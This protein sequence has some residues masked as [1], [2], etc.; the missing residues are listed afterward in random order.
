MSAFTS[1]HEPG[2]WLVAAILLGIVVAA[3]WFVVRTAWRMWMVIAYWLGIPYLALLTG[4]VSPRLMGVQFLD[5]PITFR[6]GVGLIIGLLVLVMVARLVLQPSADDHSVGTAPPTIWLVA[7]ATVGLCG[8]EQLFWC[9]LR[10][11]L[12]ELLL[13]V[14]VVALPAYWA[15]WLAA[16]LALPLTI[17]VHGGA[18]WRVLA[19]G[20]LVV[21]SVVFF[22]TRNFWLCW[23][24]HAVLWMVLARFA[25]RG[26]RSDR[27]ALA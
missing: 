8:A 6:L 3:A 23:F 2:F 14:T 4:A 5:W 13:S 10:G 24:V 1:F 27:I 21:T 22:Y 11:A 17:A 15:V 26:G 16:L 7:L 9:F 19:V 18:S 20:A 25:R 12:W